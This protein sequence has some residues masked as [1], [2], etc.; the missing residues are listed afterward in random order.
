MTCI[1]INPSTPLPTM[2]PLNTG[3]AAVIP[4]AIRQS[5]RQAAWRRN[6]R[7]AAVVGFSVSGAAFGVSWLAATAGGTFLILGAWR[8]T[9]LRESASSAHNGMNGSSL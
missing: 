1:P 6:L 2:Q 3:P 4:H 7:T 9:Q 8:Y 5:L